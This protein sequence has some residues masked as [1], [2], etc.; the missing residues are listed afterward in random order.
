[1]QY[2][3]NLREKIIKKIVSQKA[4]IQKVHLEKRV[5]S[6]NQGRLIFGSRHCFRVQTLHQMPK[7]TPYGANR[8]LYGISNTLFLYR[9]LQELNLDGIFD[10][11]F[12]K[13]GN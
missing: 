3:N 4:F 1:M 5:S 2:D 10:G 12:G 13:S 11:R 7:Q 6:Y 8:S 9:V